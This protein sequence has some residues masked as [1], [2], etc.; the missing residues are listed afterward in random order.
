MRQPEILE[1]LNGVV[2]RYGLREHISLE[3]AMT[4]ASFDEFTGIGP[5]TP[6]EG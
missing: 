2:D 4:D 5:C 1:Y 6:T 3:T